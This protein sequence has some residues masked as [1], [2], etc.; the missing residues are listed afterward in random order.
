MPA[1]PAQ[2]SSAAQERW[3]PAPPPARPRPGQ[4]MP[5]A[6]SPADK[7]NGA[8]G[9]RGRAVPQ[10][11][12]VDNARS[13]TERAP[14]LAALAPTGLPVG[15]G[16]IAAGQLFGRLLNPVCGT[17]VGRDATGLEVGDQLRAQ[18]ASDKGM[19]IT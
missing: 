10:T 16:Q 5:K 12:F 2:D 13:T 6:R 11:G 8:G 7:P 19:A 18:T 17:D 14:S 3:S 1:Q 15:H 9:R 4:R